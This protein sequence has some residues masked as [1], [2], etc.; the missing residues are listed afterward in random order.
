MLMKTTAE[1][2]V[3]DARNIMKIYDKQKINSNINTSQLDRVGSS[4]LEGSKKWAKFTY[5]GDG[6]RILPTI[7]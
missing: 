3:Y 5:F 4:L 1:D 7:F 6:I 2:N